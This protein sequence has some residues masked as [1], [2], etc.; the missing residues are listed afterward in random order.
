MDEDLAMDNCDV[1]S[2]MVSS[3]ARMAC[4]TSCL[5]GI[6]GLSA[7]ITSHLSEL[8]VIKSSTCNEDWEGVEGGG[9]GGGGGEMPLTSTLLE[10]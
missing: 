5:E 10:E 3:I 2:L 9:G 8:L 4:K 6:G 1:M 7:I